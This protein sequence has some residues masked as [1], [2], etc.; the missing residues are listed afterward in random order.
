MKFRELLRNLK[1]K[2]LRVVIVL[3]NYADGEDKDVYIGT[4]GTLLYWKDLQNFFDLTV[5]CIH[6]DENCFVIFL[7]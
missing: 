3:E 5:T 6:T 7:S 2:S 4:L 1:L